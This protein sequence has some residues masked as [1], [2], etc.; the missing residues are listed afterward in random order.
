MTAGTTDA[1]LVVAFGG[2]EH[3]D[4]VRPFLRR[5]LAGRNVPEGR[6]Q[7]VAH[8]YDAIGGKSPL[9]EITRRQTAALARTLAAR[10]LDVP[11]RVGFRHS[12]P[13][14]RDALRD[15]A[16]TGAKRVAC[17]IMA[18]HE[19]A[20]SRGRYRDACEAARAA[21]GATAPAVAYTPSFHAHPGFVRANVEHV[22][23]A[24]RRIPERDRDAAVLV[25][26]AHSVPARDAEPYVAG[27][28]ESA[29]LVAQALGRANPRIAYQSRSGSPLEPW[30]EPS[31]EEVIAAEAERGTR[32]LIVSPIGFVC[33]HVEVLYDLDLEAAA[34][35]RARGIG[36][37]RAAT[38]GEHPA[39]IAALADGL[40]TLG[41]A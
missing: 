38:V 26:G 5:V 15:L 35:A 17:V 39:F 16:D 30:L 2:P 6:M 7:E 10:G 20:A 37:H 40:A 24:E 14:L 41:G 1:V 9:P 32:H 19:G 27:L 23:E 22:R 11:V 4:D 8:H 29:Q 18:A 21:L 13:D 34:S 3:P 33:D 25:F 36:F 12:A 31:I 28:T